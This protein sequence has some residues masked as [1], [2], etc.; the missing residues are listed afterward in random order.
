MIKH[1]QMEINPENPISRTLKKF[2]QEA[3]KEKQN[4]K[5]I[6]QVPNAVYIS[7]CTLCL[8]SFVNNTM[9]KVTPLK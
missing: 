3:Y 6:E 9:L 1:I 2:K 8:H 5:T 7:E 4:K